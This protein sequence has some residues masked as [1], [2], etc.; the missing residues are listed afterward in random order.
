MKVIHCDQIESGPV[1][2]EGAVNCRMRCLLTP[3]DPAPG[4]SMRHFEV[5]TGGHTPKHSHPYEHEV[6]V[7]EGSGVVLEDDC[8]HQLRPGSAVYVSRGQLHQFR[9]TGPGTLK[10][11]CVI[12]H[13]V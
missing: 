6:F 2:K 13:P 1:G 10:F 12:P 11:L 3:D 9:N 7:L 5:A 4:F 8:E